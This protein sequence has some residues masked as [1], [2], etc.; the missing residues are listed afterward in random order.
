ML[1]SIYPTWKAHM[2]V[3]KNLPEPT[4]KITWIYPPYPQHYK[5]LGHDDLQPLQYG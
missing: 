2:L 1:E 5:T 4:L 3:S